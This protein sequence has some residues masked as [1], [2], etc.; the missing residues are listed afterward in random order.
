[1]LWFNIV[2]I[3]IVYLQFIS[4]QSAFI[5]IG[6]GGEGSAGF[7]AEDIFVHQVRF[8]LLQD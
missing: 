8:R 4:P 6:L 2:M 3:A 7:R 5:N 1:M